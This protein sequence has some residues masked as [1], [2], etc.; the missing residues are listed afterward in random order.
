MVQNLYFITIIPPKPAWPGRAW[1]GAGAGAGPG[2]GAGT[3]AGGRGPGPGAGGRA[4][5][6]DLWNPKM[7]TNEKYLKVKL[8]PILLENI[9]RHL[10]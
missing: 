10:I 4:K 7:E 2:P 9:P 1:A 3:G 5:K 8:S 6:N